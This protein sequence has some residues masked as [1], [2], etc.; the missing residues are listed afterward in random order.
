MAPDNQVRQA[1]E[2]RAA[3]GRMTLEEQRVMGQPDVGWEAVVWGGM[4]WDPD[5]G[6]GASG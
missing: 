6:A 3:I 4:G 2:A 5:E 1:R